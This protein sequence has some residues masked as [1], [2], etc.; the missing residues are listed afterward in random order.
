[1]RSPEC[2]YDQRRY[3]VHQ[4]MLAE[5]PISSPKTQ[6][7]SG[8]TPNRVLSHKQQIIKNKRFEKLIFFKE[9]CYL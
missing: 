6:K 5:N 8:E 4:K 3:L 2:L 9:L 1:M 7:S